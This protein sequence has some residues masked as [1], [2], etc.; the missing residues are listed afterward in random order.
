MTDHLMDPVS[1][2]ILISEL[3]PD[4]FVR[5]TNKADNEIYIFRGCEKPNLM[6]EVGR[7]RDVSF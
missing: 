6:N 4:I 3:S 2:D 7:L 1:R 5:K